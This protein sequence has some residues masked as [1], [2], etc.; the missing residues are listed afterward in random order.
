VTTAGY[1]DSTLEANDGAVIE[2]VPW[3][4]RPNKTSSSPPV[5][6]RIMAFSFQREIPKHRAYL[7]ERL[8]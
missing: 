3:E 6:Q 7:G 2:V 1:L 4:W 8:S 5:A